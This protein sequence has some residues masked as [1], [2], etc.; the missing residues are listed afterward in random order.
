MIAAM[1]ALTSPLKSPHHQSLT[2]HEFGF[3]LRRNTVKDVAF[4]RSVVDPEKQYACLHRG[5]GA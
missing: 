1:A 3:M 4:S 2:Q 5:R